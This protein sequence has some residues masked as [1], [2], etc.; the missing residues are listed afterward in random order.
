MWVAKLKRHERKIEGTLNEHEGLSGA[1]LEEA[2][3]VMIVGD[4]TVVFPVIVAAVLGRGAREP[5]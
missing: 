3:T 2:K 1:T 4:A 5:K